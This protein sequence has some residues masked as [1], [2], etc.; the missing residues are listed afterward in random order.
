MLTT[1]T[2]EQKE[3][4]IMQCCDMR[5]HLLLVADFADIVQTLH[6]TLPDHGRVTFIGEYDERAPGCR[7]AHF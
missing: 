6:K 5:P 1:T 3:A 7:H 2:I 4:F